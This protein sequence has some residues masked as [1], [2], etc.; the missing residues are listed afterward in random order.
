MSK[1]KKLN[2]AHEL[3]KR[4]FRVAIFGSARVKKGDQVYKDVFHLAMLIGR[5]GYDIVTGGGPGLMEA[6]NSGHA[7]GD[8]LRKADS[9][10]LTIKLPGKQSTN[11]YVELREDF[12]QFSKR[13]DEFMKLANVIVVTEGGLGT[14]LEF[15][16]TWQLLQVR[17]MDY[18]P[19]ILIGTMWKKLIDWIK[20]YSLKKKLMSPQDFIF[21]HI[22]KNNSAAIKIIEKFY[23]IYCKEGRCRKIS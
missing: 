23:D 19:I 22:A 17:H 10:G 12:T 4:D 2:L 18:K 1:I 7:A 11:R 3:K 13:L 20:K 15:A 6:A 9:I 14:L 21:I 5:R 8:K 16:F